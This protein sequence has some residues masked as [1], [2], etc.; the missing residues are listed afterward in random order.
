MCN[1]AS[2]NLIKGTVSLND[3]LRA[4]RFRGTAWCKKHAHEV[5]VHANFPREKMQRDRANCPKCQHATARMIV[6]RQLLGL[7][8]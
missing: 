4:H 6:I 2:T 3:R 1:M 5:Q 8:T 7:G